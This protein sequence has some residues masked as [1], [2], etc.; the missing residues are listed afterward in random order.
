MFL[1]PFN[2]HISARFIKAVKL[3]RFR[4]E[5]ISCKNQFRGKRIVFWCNLVLLFFCNSCSTDMYRKTDP[6]QANRFKYELLITTAGS[7]STSV[8]LKNAIIRINDK[9]QEIIGFIDGTRIIEVPLKY[10]KS[11]RFPQAT[12][13][14]NLNN[15]ALKTY[16]NRYKMIIQADGE[17][18]NPGGVTI[19]CDSIPKFY[20]FGQESR[21]VKRRFINCSRYIQMHE[22][23]FLRRIDTKLLSTVPPSNKT[24]GHN[25][26]KQKK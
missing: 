5:H 20:V 22:I 13:A 6:V 14:R 18:G 4:S 8:S 7:Y 25:Q 10:I 17:P 12:S 9:E 15:S 23:K 11:I 21:Y 26:P 3:T 1:Q 16:R 19:A 2:H 24:P